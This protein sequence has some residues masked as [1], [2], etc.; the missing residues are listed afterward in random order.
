LLLPLV[1]PVVEAALPRD[2]LQC[3]LIDI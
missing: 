3:G 2:A 1:F